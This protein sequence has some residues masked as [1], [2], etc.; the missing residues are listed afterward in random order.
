MHSFLVLLQQRGEEIQNSV[1]ADIS[2]LEWEQVV[3]RAKQKSALSVFS[4]RTYSVYKCA[5]ESKIMTKV[6]V[7]FYSILIKNGLY[8]KR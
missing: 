4:N 5:L 2:E 8:L 6:F 7:L 1:S 3:K